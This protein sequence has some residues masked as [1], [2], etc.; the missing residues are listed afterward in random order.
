MQDTAT[1]RG[2][3]L[4]ALFGLNRA[5]LAACKW[6]A[7][8]LVAA[9]AAIVSAS[10]IARYGFNSSFAWSEDA[11]KFLLVW[12]T[13]IGAPLGFRHGA[14]VACALLP[15]VRSTLINRAVAAIVHG[16]VLFVMV[17]LAWQSWKL[18]WNGRTQQAITIGDISMLWV[19]VC[20]PIG[21]AVMALVALEE[22]LRSLVGLPT[23]EQEASDAISTRG[24]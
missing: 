1:A 22:L 2:I 21:S 20:M 9:V 4:R 18:A 23:L 6:I 10:V 12:L 14:H 17:M 24:I 16:V 13:F 15:R 19:F 7:V 8:G 11:A 5:L 3:H